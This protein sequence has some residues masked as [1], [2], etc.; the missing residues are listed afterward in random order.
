MLSLVIQRV[1][2]LTDIKPS[3]NMVYG[4]MLNVT[5]LSDFVLIVS[6]QRKIVLI[7]IRRSIIMLSVIILSAIKLECHFAECHCD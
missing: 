2:M 3:I 4:I 7:V 5:I 1:I 6:M